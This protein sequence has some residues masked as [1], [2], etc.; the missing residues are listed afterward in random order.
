VPEDHV[1]LSL[2]EAGGLDF[3]KDFS[4]ADFKA[5]QKRPELATFPYLATHYVGFSVDKYPVSLPAVRRAIAHAIDRREVIAAIGGA[6]EPASG[7][8][9]PELPGGRKGEGLKFDPLRARSLL[10]MAGIDPS[11]LSLEMLIQTSDKSRLI[12]EAVR[13]QLGKN[14]G[15]EVKLQPFEHRAFRAQL[16]LQAYPLFQLQWS[17]DYPDAEN[18]LSVFLPGS[19]NNRTGWKNPA[20][21]GLMQEAA[22]SSAPAQRLRKFEQADELLVDRDAVIVPLYHSRL[23]ALISRRCRG[24]RLSPMN[25]LFLREVSVD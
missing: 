17:A 16:D 6:H 11:S 12:G 25:Y 19:G 15:I 22:A 23:S 10:R 20:Y 21:P 3:I 18:F 9:P 13:S 8:V 14:L 4:A 24:V 7:F 2:L 5:I 1:A